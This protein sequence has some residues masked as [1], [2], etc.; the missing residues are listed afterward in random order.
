MGDRRKRSLENVVSLLYM[1][2]VLLTL[3][4]PHTYS[5]THYVLLCSRFLNI[6]RTRASRSTTSS[7]RLF[8]PQYQVLVVVC[9][10]W[11]RCCVNTTSKLCPIPVSRVLMNLPHGTFQQRT[12]TRSI[13][14]TNSGRFFDPADGTSAVDFIGTA[15]IF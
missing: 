6:V 9:P 10:I 3:A 1:V 15:H 14:L 5:I 11:C 12:S 7:L 4:P 8:V 2:C 13:S